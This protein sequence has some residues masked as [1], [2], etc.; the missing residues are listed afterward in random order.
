MTEGALAPYLGEPDEGTPASIVWAGGLFFIVDRFDQGAARPI[1]I[2]GR[3]RCPLHGPVMLL[4]GIGCGLVAA[5]AG[6]GGA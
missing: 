5:L 1:D 3:A 6:S 2:T 4:P